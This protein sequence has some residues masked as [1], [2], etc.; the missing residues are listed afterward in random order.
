MSSGCIGEED[1]MELLQNLQGKVPQKT[2]EKQRF[3]LENEHVEP[4][5]YKMDVWKMILIY[6]WVVFRFHFNF[7][8]RKD[9][10]DMDF[11]QFIF[12]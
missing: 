5:K 12:E 10:N 6:N 11:K 4:K 7:R 3:T 1:A 2:N 9:L 8:G